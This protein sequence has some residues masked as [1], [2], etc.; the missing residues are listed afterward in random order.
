MRKRRRKVIPF[1]GEGECNRPANELVSNLKS[2]P[3]AFVIACVTDRR[4]KAE[5][6]WAI[7]YKLQERVGSFEFDDLYEIKKE[8][9]A[10]YFNEPNSLHFLS[11]EMPNCVHS[12]IRIIGDQY[13]GDASKMWSGR[14]SSAT[15]VYRF[16]QIHGVGLK[17]ATMAAN[18]LVRGFKIKF[19]DYYSIDMSADVHVKRVFHRLGLTEK[20][21]S[22]EEIIYRARGFYPEF[23]GLLDSPCWNIG[24]D[25]CRPRNP[26]CGQCYMKSVC[27]SAGKLGEI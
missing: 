22:P 27:P 11:Q 16:L 24:R 7:P 4:I 13:D 14:P 21:A 25:W 19:K 9:L 18:I 1:A 15:V 26:K 20:K 8:E 3:H 2:Y 6:A 23:P 12:A 17:I 5:R 10:D